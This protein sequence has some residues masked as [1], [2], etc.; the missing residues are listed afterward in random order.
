MS[1]AKVT[2]FAG[3]VERPSG[4]R[5]F[6]N[7]VLATGQPPVGPHEMAGVAVGIS[8][9][10]ILMLGLGLPE[11]SGG[12]HFG[13]DF[14]G[15]QAGFVYIGAGVLGNP[16]LLVGGVEDRRSIARPDIVPLPIARARV[17]NLEEELQDLPVAD[18]G[19]VKDDLDCFCMCSVV[20]IRRIGR[21]ASRVADAGGLH[22]RRYTQPDLPQPRGPC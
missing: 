9:E 15:P 19:R 6:L 14:A 22:R 20:A 5:L 3:R 16:A 4:S 12:H 1:P 10:V 13:H 17:V 11:V 7:L 18:P 8:L 21:V 2:P